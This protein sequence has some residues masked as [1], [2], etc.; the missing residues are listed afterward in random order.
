MLM[1]AID[2]RARRVLIVGGGRVA[3]RKV[4][5][6]LERVGRI[7]IVSP[8][9]DDRLHAV[10]E[11]REDVIWHERAWSEGDLDEAPWL[12]VA[13]TDDR[14]LNERIA[15][16]ATAAGCLVNAAHRGVG[17]TCTF[18]AVA[19]RDTIQVGVITAG[20]APALGARLRD[21]LAP[22]LEIWAVAAHALGQA[23]EAITRSN[24]DASARRDVWR[25]LAA[26]VPDQWPQTRDEARALVERALIERLPPGE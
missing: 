6:L 24:L 23:R 18:P 11:A 10:V 13:A 19:A 20:E 5:Y 1:L 17:A 25:D 8:H 21:W 2:A 9:L 7:E 4:T 3:Y 14:A 12:V 15:R 22:Q 26:L 16:L